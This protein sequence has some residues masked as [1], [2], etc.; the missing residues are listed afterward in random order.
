[1]KDDIYYMKKAIKLSEKAKAKGEIP[2]GA[3]VVEKG[4]IIAK[5]INQRDERNIVTKHAEI[6]AIEKAN[7]YKKNWRL[8]ECELYV[9]LEPCLMC[10]TVI[11]QARIKK[12]IYGA[13]I[14]DAKNKQMV[15]NIKIEKE[16]VKDEQTIKQC[17]NQLDLFFQKIREKN[18]LFPGK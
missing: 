6:I 17:E 7:R 16:Q 8:P 4:K 13:A 14:R 12:V 5:G 2:V 9:T 11:E 1:M 15:Q 3:I 18:K 10:S